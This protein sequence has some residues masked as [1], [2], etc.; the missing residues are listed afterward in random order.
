M[1]LGGYHKLFI[2]I[3]QVHF[4]KLKITDRKA[5]FDINE[6]PN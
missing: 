4:P 1:F 5:D 2:A 3:E 6:K